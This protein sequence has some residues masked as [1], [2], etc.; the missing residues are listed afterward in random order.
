M[1][2]KHGV[3]LDLDGTLMDGAQAH[4]GA[5]AL[6]N[7][8]QSLGIPLLVMTNSVLSPDAVIKRLQRCGM[9]LSIENIL[10]PIVAVNAYIQSQK[11]SAVKCI[12]SERER[13]QLL[14]VSDTEIPDA[15]VLLD[16]EEINADY[17]LLQKLMILCRQNTPFLA[18]SGSCY[19]TKNG[20]RHIDTGAFV[21]LLELAS[22]RKIQIMGKPSPL[23]FQMAYKLLGK[24][25]EFVY[26]VGDD[27]STDMRGAAA[28]GS[29]GCLI[30]TGKYQS[31]DA[32]L[33]DVSFCF[34]DLEGFSQLF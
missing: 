2:L 22:D 15:V 17:R 19:Y 7:R 3:I 24:S 20:I 23:Y 9:H 10:N 4:A 5:A 25:P 31:G 11:W 21:K 30:K 14:H 16:F 27:V 26:V 6:V 8:L 34:E 18:A 28:T 1:H 12:G 29:I 32:E 13:C 33:P